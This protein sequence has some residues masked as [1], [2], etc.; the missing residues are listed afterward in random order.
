M[1]LSPLYL[2]RFYGRI[3]KGPAEHEDVTLDAIRDNAS[4]LESKISVKMNDN[5]SLS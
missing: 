2:C 5:T 4:G 1:F 3:A